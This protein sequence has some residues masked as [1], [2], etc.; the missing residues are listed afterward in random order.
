MLEDSRM[1]ARRYSVSEIWWCLPFRTDISPIGE[2]TALTMKL[3]MLLIDL[4]L[5][6]R[7]SRQ[8]W[9]DIRLNLE[10]FVASFVRFSSLSGLCSAAALLYTSLI[11][12]YFHV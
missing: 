4:V 5:N 9:E 11:Q 2:N 6:K 8:V 12:Y 10:R 7:Q 3:V 1:I